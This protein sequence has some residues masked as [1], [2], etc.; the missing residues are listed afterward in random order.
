MGSKSDHDPSYDF[1]REDSSSGICVILLTNKQ[2]SKQTNSH[3]NNTSLVEIINVCTNKMQ[4][5]YYVLAN[6]KR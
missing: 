2:T 3:E 1:L 4:L 6:E 5:I